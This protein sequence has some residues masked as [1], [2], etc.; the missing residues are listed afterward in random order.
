MS[1]LARLG[2]NQHWQDRRQASATNL[3]VDVAR[4]SVA[5]RGA[6]HV[7]AEAGTCWAELPGKAYHSA[8]D[9]RQL[10]V[11]GDWI[12]AERVAA[13]CSGDGAARIVEVLPRDSFL[14]RRAAGRATEPQ[15]IVANV[16]IGF[17]VTSMNTDLSLP[18]LDR[19]VAMLRE[20]KIEPVV[21][22]SKCDLAEEHIVERARHQ[23]A[24]SGITAIAVSAHSGVGME[25]LRQRVRADQTAILLGSSGVGK[26]SI[27]N[28]LIG[29][30]RQLIQGIRADE[31]GQHTTTR[32][33]LM[34]TD[35]GIWI[36]SPGMRE[37]ARWHDDD[38]DAFDDIAKIAS[39]CKFADC[40]HQNEPSCAVRAAVTAGL[41]ESAR[42]QSF[43]KLRA[44]S[45]SQSQ[46]QR[47]AQQK[48]QHLQKL[49]VN[50]T[51]RA[52][53]RR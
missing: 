31:R 32:R 50:R 43:H 38:A 17:V 45:E 53:R 3:D 39:D 49:G 35:Y 24:A 42:L 28:G 25:Q 11:V 20:G 37:L 6:Y 26:S 7:I 52:N 14:V 15:P 46:L 4:V 13:A 12:I 47:V 23:L 40:Q 8:T 36:D 30:T 22:L 21:V 5:H 34:A 33:E 16:D 27:I 19:Y 44:E 41:L 10:P 48:Q 2:W 9:R 1:N 51:G 29:E 18:R